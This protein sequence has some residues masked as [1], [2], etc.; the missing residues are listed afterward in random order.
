MP[1]TSAHRNLPL[2]ANI[3]WSLSGN[4]VYALCQW[5]IL[6]IIAKIG[7]PEQVGQFVLGLTIAA[8]IYG[9]FYF[10]LRNILASDGSGRFAFCDF[11]SLVLLG[12]FA[13]II[14]VAI[15]VLIVG[16]KIESAIIILAVG[17]SKSVETISDI[18]YGLFQKYER[19]DRIATSQILKAIFSLIM[20]FCALKITGSILGVCVALILTWS[21]VLFYYDKKQAELVLKREA[22]FAN[23]SHYYELNLRK[24]FL[25]LGQERIKKLLIMA[26]PMGIST[27]FLSLQVNIPRIFVEREFG[28]LYLGIFAAI[29][30]FD[31]L[32]KL[33]MHSVGASVTA[34]L[35]NFNLRR[36]KR[37]FGVVLLKLIGLAVLLGIIGIVI[38]EL[39]DKT[40][41]TIFYGKDYYVQGLF[42]SIMIG[43]GFSYISTILGY[44]M[45]A[46]RFLRLQMLVSVT[47]TMALL[48]LCPWFMLKNGIV[49]VAE[50]IAYTRAFEVVML[51]IIV[52]NYLLGV[53]KQNDDD[54]IQLLES[55]KCEKNHV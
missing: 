8:P 28:E 32:G 55:E 3:V 21:M 20:T 22:N 34:Q 38:A 50:A 45:V 49:G 13:S 4:V 44:A 41:L 19:L 5:G 18:Y 1:A 23:Y 35:A 27:L 39:F 46:C 48:S 7:S 36:R 16:Y 43:A 25:E 6:V 15:V 51:L 42:T 11:L 53:N 12:S 52:G 54:S 26:L 33:T 14:C 30:Y 17:C 37:D 10:E 29:A 2:T 9:L 40:V 47:V 31:K 24:N